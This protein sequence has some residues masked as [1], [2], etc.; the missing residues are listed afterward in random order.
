MTTTTLLPPHHHG[1]LGHDLDVSFASLP[2]LSTLLNDDAVWPLSD[3]CSLLSVDV[4]QPQPS[5]FCAFASSTSARPQHIVTD[6]HRSLAVETSWF[7]RLTGS[8]DIQMSVSDESL[9]Y[10]SDELMSSDVLDQYLSHLLTSPPGC[11]GNYSNVAGDWQSGLNAVSPL[12]DQLQPSPCDVDRL[13]LA[14][15][16][17]FSNQ[18]CFQNTPRAT[19]VRSTTFMCNATDSDEGAFH[20]SLNERHI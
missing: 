6:N 4:V 17:S 13:R 16:K 11:L 18:E 10:N 7:Q 5:T 19:D 2:Q 8:D 12:A 15:S 3:A 14:T 1:L 9:W 20:R